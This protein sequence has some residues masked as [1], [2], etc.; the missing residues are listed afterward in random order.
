M[1]QDG[2]WINENAVM[3]I[4]RVLGCH[5]TFEIKYLHIS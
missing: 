3:N 2:D 5:Y 1:G 4:D